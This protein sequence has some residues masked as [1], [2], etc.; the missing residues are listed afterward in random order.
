MNI[1]LKPQYRLPKVVF[2]IIFELKII[3]FEFVFLYEYMSIYVSIHMYIENLF[4]GFVVLGHRD[5]KF[6][7]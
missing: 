6:I 3:L 4:D 1:Q 2:E 7:K 5:V